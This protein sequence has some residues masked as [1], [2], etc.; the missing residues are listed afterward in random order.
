MNSIMAKRSIR[1]LWAK[2]TE[3]KALSSEVRTMLL[4]AYEPLP[5]SSKSRPPADPQHVSETHER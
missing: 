1:D 5:T 2:R 4:K 3:K